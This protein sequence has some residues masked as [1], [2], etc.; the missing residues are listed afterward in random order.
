M[1]TKLALL[2]LLA[3][4]ALAHA[5][6]FRAQSPDERAT[7]ATKSAA[8]RVKGHLKGIYPGQTTSMKVKVTNNGHARITLRSLKVKV[9][10]TVA[11][12]PSSSLKFT[13]FKGHK[14]IRGDAT[15]SMRLPARMKA[16]SPDAC[17]GARYQLT[18]AGKAS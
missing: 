2:C 16:T 14:A 9:R 13:P 4:A 3:A 12:C 15:I 18:Y 17:Q 10:S 1:A 8:F 11:G 5:T 7:V 6:G